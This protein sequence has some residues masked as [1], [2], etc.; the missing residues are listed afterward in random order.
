M[1]MHK[2]Y[3]RWLIRGHLGAYRSIY[4]PVER[5]NKRI[6][7]PIT[8]DL[9]VSNRT[10]VVIEGYPRS[11]NTF[12]AHAFR[13]AQERDVVIATRSHAAAPVFEGIRRNLPCLV[14]IREPR[15]AAISAYVL[16]DGLL[17]PE[18][19]L[20]H[21]RRYYKTL[22]PRLSRVLVATFSQVRSDFG[23]VTQRLNHKYNVRFRPF[24]HSETNVRAVFQS[25]DEFQQKRT[26]TADNH[27][28]VSR[29]DE[30]RNALKRNAE[31]KFDHSSVQGL[32]D[33][34]HEL[35]EQIRTRFAEQP[36]AQ[37]VG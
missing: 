32:L 15:D 13:M 3:W 24:V 5:I 29:P 30:V 35:Y 11:G 6:F 25:I 2:C 8:R 19:L 16:S 1:M 27:R 9:T 23:T 4:L 33:S 10:E 12:A 17:C 37:N 31:S 22:E 28:T 7:N 18:F 20:R 34:C 21:Y 14:L 26:K 36:E